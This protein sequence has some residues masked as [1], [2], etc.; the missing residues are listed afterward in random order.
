MATRPEIVIGETFLDI[1]AGLTEG[2]KYVAQHVGGGVVEFCD[3]ATDPTNENVGRMRLLTYEWLEF[4][5]EA[6]EPTWARC[7]SGEAR[8]VI[9][10]Q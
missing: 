9:N 1:T 2:Q 10:E 6:A 5:R 3:F 4:T 7:R 8:F